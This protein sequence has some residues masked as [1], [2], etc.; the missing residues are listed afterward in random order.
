M[1]FNQIYLIDLGKLRGCFQ[2]SPMHRGAALR[3]SIPVHVGSAGLTRPGKIILLLALMT[4]FWPL[5][6]KASWLSDITGINIDLPAGRVSFGPPRPDRIPQMLQQLPK[7]ATQFFLNPGG[8]ALAF[9]IRQAK[10][11]AGRDCQRVPGDIQQ[12]LSSFFPAEVFNGVCWNTYGQ[13]FAIDSLLLNEFNQGAVTLEDVIVFK[14]GQVASDP[15]LWAHELTHVQQYRSLGLE[16]FAHLYSFGSAQSIE[17]EAYR[18]QSFVQSRL[19]AAAAQSY[20]SATPGWSPQSQISNNQYRQVAQNQIN[21]MICTRKENYPGV[22]RVY[23]TCPIPIRV[24]QFVMVNLATGQNY[25]MPCTTQVCILGPNTYSEWPE[26]VMSQTAL[27]Q[28]V[29]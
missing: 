8:D 22:V 21:P 20:W 12:Q 15:A 24:V 10:A 1:E 5:K 27:G 28:I 25:T 2:L 19:S 18:F 11:A 4:L 7:D 6:G 13:R 26:P 3:R 29:W 17:S 9:A 16:T 14:D 23:N